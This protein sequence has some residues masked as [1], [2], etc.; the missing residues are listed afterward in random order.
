MAG[1]SVLVAVD[2]LLLE[3]LRMPD[4]NPAGLRTLVAAPGPTATMRR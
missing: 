1:S 3:R 4:V 2:A